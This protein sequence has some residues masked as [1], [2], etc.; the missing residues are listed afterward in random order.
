[1]NN[2]S[3]EMMTYKELYDWGVQDR[4][5]LFEAVRVFFKADKTVTRSIVVAMLLLQQTDL[6]CLTLKNLDLSGLDLKRV[7]FGGSKIENCDFSNADL[8]NATFE[9]A[10]VKNCNFNEALFVNTF[11]FSGKFKK[12]N[13]DGVNLIYAQ[14]LPKGIE[15]ENR[16]VNAGVPECCLAICSETESDTEL[17]IRCLTTLLDMFEGQ[18]K[19][20]RDPLMAALMVYP[21]LKISING[22]LSKQGFMTFFDRYY[23]CWLKKVSKLES[24]PTVESL[25][26][27]G[28]SFWAN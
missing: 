15:K 22:D 7:N 21:Y 5:S 28:F 3:V 16:C 2:K 23:P 14:T 8:S 13:F 10:R 20:C 1:M 19:D 9:Y 24:L 11:M 17:A 12:C 27:A 18:K 4:S 6:G 26:E 25:E